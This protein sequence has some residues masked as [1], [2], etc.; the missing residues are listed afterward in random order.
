[1]LLKKSHFAIYVNFVTVLHHNMKYE[2][3]L[4]GGL[5][6]AKGGKGERGGNNEVQKQGT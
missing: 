5:A 3:L 1:M 2:L 6:I 4:W